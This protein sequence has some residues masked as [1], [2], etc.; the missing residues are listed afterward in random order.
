M[1]IKRY[2]MPVTRAM[3]LLSGLLCLAYSGLAAILNALRYGGDNE[4]AGVVIAMA[5]AAIVLGGALLPGVFTAAWSAKDRAGAAVFALAWAACSLFIFANAAG[6]LAHHKGEASQSRVDAIGAHTRAETDLS[7]ARLALDGLKAAPRW[8]STKQ[9]TEATAPQSIIFCEKVASI[10]AEIARLSAVLDKG[11]PASADAGSETLSWL[12]G[13]RPADVS[14]TFEIYAGVLAEM[15]ASL[16]FFGASRMSWK[17]DAGLRVGEAVQ[18]ET[19]TQVVAAELKAAGVQPR[20]L[21]KPAPMLG[22]DG[23]P[24]KPMPR[25]SKKTVH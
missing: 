2:P 16:F 1:Q 11:R 9:C 6:F 3:F 14:K 20:T 19:T 13:F 25:R 10:E 21:V 7:V 12:T 15:M 17:S 23:E 22:F 4:I 5:F 8:Q 18:K 24:V